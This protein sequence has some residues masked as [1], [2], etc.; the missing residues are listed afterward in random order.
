MRFDAA[1]TGVARI[2]FTRDETGK[3]PACPSPTLLIPSAACSDGLT[4]YISTEDKPEPLCTFDSILAGDFETG[5]VDNLTCSVD[6][7]ALATGE[8]CKQR[9]CRCP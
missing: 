2:T 9:R 1:E 7:D 6:V 8:K 3:K 4:V 5:T